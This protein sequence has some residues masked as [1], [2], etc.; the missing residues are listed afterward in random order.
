MDGRGQVRRR[1]QAPESGQVFIK[2]DYGN[3]LG[4]KNQRHA[5]GKLGVLCL[6]TENEHGK[7]RAHASTDGGKAYQHRFGNAPRLPYCT[8]LVNGIKH[9]CYQID[10]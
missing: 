3:Y 1:R 6:V 2:T 5:D 7:K 8:T 9:K 4:N 10:Y